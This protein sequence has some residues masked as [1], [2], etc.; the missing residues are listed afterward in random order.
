M[1]RK[2]TTIFGQPKSKVPPKPKPKPKKKT[3]RVSLTPS[4]EAHHIRAQLMAGLRDKG[5]STFSGGSTKEHSPRINIPGEFR[6]KAIHLMIYLLSDNSMIRFVG[7]GNINLISG[8]DIIDRNVPFDICLVKYKQ[9]QPNDIEF[10]ERIEVCFWS[11]YETFSE[12]IEIRPNRVS[13]FI[14]NAVS[15]KSIES[16]KAKYEK[17]A[18]LKAPFDVVE[19]IDIVYTW[20]DDADQDW[21]ASKQEWESKLKDQIETGSRSLHDERFRNRDEL[22]YSLRSIEMFAPYVNKIYIVTAGQVPSWLNVE[23]DKIQIVDHTEIFPPECLPTFNSSAIETRLHHIEGLSERF[24]YFNDD[25]FLG[26]QTSATDFYYNNGIMKFFPSTTSVS[27]ETI[28]DDAEEYILADVNAINLFRDTYGFSPRNVM[29]HTPHPVFKSL[30]QELEDTFKNEF[31]ACAMQKFR[32]AQDLRPIAFM[33]PHFASHKQKAVIFPH[34]H[35]YLALWKP[36]IQGQ[37]NNVL[38]KRSYM[39]FCVNDVGVPS[40]MVEYTNVITIKFLEEYF[41]YKSSFEK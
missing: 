12:A 24:I 15:F 33:H 17:E 23:H 7:R 35:R 26:R 34:E 8:N 22:K 29:Q 31:N 1:F 14:N 38:A 18:D 6:E 5:I 25:V 9:S 41:P 11:E 27:P 30:L 4:F 20:V 36:S 3:N 10:V 2:V 16:L 32:S 28:G 13:S 39:T 21:L 19:P 40:D 37:M